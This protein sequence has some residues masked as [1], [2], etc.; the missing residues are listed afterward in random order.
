MP[1]A[2]D[3]DTVAP[4]DFLNSTLK[5][6]LPPR[7]IKKP[8]NKKIKHL[9]QP[10]NGKSHSA[11]FR[12]NVYGILGKTKHPF[13][14]FLVKP[15]VFSFRERDT[16]E[17]II[18][19]LR[20]HWITNLTWILITLSMIIAPILLTTV[21]LL[22]SFPPAYQFISIIFWYLITFIYS[23]EQLLSWY[24]NV[25]IITDER[26]I[27]IDFNNLLSKNFSEA[28][29]SMIQDV[30]STIIGVS[31]TFFNFGNIQIQTAAEVPEITFEKVPNPEIIIKVLGQ[32]RQEEELEN[33]EGRVK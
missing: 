7:P 25:Y 5:S 16:D 17:E 29:I 11:Q 31:Q 18:L 28:K 10:S 30:T 3:L 2:K 6:P 27:D 8:Q 32:L 26:V 24:F 1:R 15:K 19:V 4:D 23:F 22:E 12:Q 33:I 9:H 20:R 14:S 21:P 13:S